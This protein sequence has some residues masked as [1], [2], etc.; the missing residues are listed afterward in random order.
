MKIVFSIQ[1]S[2]KG[3]AAT[4][5]NEAVKP[6]VSPENHKLM[7]PLIKILIQTSNKCYQQARA[8]NWDDNSI[9]TRSLWSV[10]K[11]SVNNYTCS[12]H[13]SKLLPDKTEGPP[14][15]RMR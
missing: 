11:G 13:L 8:H 3:M 4:L 14:C 6:R 9:V 10:N 1:I 15:L 12:K 7:K 2:G 5:P